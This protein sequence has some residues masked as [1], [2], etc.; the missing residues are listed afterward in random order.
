MRGDL[1]PFELT[2]IFLTGM[3]GVL[4]SQP[5]PIGPE[6]RRSLKRMIDVFVRGVAP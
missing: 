6:L 3:F 2:L 5:D 1:M 4:L